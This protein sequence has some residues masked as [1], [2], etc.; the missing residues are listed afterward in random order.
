MNLEKSPVPLG[1]FL[2]SDFPIVS[3]NK[4]S[5]LQV[6]K[7]IQLKQQSA[8]VFFY[9]A[10]IER[11]VAMFPDHAI[12]EVCVTCHNEHPNTPK[13]DWKL[14]DIMGA[15]TWLY[16]DETVSLEEIMDVVF[17]IRQ[18]IAAAYMKYLDK[19]KTFQSSPDIG[20]KWPDQ[21]Y[22]LPDSKTFMDFYERQASLKTMSILLSKNNLRND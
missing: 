9:S 12:S 17:E 10:D 13:Q 1:L 18:S 2:G 3:T 15:T 6:E 4:F 14:H 5:G 8:P 11:Y 21:G 19:C 16:P 22:Y 7:F 20:D